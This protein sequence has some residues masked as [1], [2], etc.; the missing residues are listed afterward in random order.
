[1]GYWACLLAAGW[2]FLF[3]A[4]AQCAEPKPPSSIRELDAALTRAFKGAKIP[5]A[6]AAIIEHGQVALLKSYG[7]PDVAKKTKVTDDTVFRAGSISKSFTSIAIMTAVE[8]KKLSMDS[9]LA[10]VAPNLRFDNPWEKTNPVR[11][12]NLLEHTTGW[13]DIS[14]HIL[15]IDE[16]SWS[17]LRGVQE[18]SPEFVS[19]WKPGYFTVYNNA[20]PAVAAVM[21]EKATGQS[22]E[23][24]MNAHV[25]RPMGMATADFDLPPALAKRIAK[26][27]ASDGTATPYQY[28]VLKPAG[29]LNTTARELAQLVRLMLGRGTVDGHRILTPA[30]IDRIERSESNLAAPLGFTEGYGLGNAPF[31]EKGIAFRGHNGEI[32]AFTA[33]EGYNTRCNCGYVLMSNG[34]D[35]LDF[36]TPAT[37]LVEHYLT[38]GMKM[39]P[40]P[41]AAV[42]D[43][44]LHQYTGIYRIITPPNALTRPFVEVLSTSLVRADHGKLTVTGLGGSNGYFP[45]NA[46]LFRRFDRELPGMAFVEKD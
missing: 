19:R 25:L 40:P 39:A 12:V 9:K 24:Y 23:N 13:P 44:D 7:Y 35:A 38:R 20:G 8:Q 16:K 28:I 21:L 15:N 30:S 1:M 22:F 3:G 34:G 42:S 27:Y 26:S 41:T 4:A 45:V 37:T 10:S 14:L 2:C 31:P 5:G 17:V 36:G 29:S 18:T 6:Q 33:V 46:H 32:D 11:L 43:A